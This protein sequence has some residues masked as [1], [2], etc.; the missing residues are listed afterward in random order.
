MVGVPLPYPAVQRGGF[1]NKVADG[2]AELPVIGGIGGVNAH[3]GIGSPAGVEHQARLQ[4]DFCKRPIAPIAVE[5]TGRPVAC[6]QDIRPAILIEIQ[7]QGSKGTRALRAHIGTLRH[8]LEGPIAPIV[9]ERQPLSLEIAHRAVVP[10]W[11]AVG[12]VQTLLQFWRPLD[13]VADDE[14]EPA[15]P[16]VIEEG[17]ARA[18]FPREQADALCSFGEGAV[19]VVDEEKVL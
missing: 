11:R 9:V 14:I 15:I 1:A 5:Q 18:P 2:N 16:V 13:V 17:G 3:T 8:V 19:A 4:A 6:D 7:D 12:T 10:G